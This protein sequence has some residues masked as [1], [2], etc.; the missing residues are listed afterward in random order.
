MCGWARDE[1]RVKLGAQCLFGYGTIL[2]A[3]ISLDNERN[4]N[5]PQNS[6][7]MITIMAIT[8]ASTTVTPIN[9]KAS[10]VY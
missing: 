8:I 6:A 4:H 1:R 3:R 9:T 2:A 7:I 5:P 10:R